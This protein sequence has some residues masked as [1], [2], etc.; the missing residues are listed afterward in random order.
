MNQCSEFK[1]NVVYFK[2]FKNSVGA[3]N[4]SIKGQF[5]LRGSQ[6]PTFCLF[7]KHFVHLCFNLFMIIQ[8][9]F[10]NSVTFQETFFMTRYCLFLNKFLMQR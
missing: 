9:A 3:R 1:A 7:C 5:F 10:A 4:I 2:V 8:S 6:L